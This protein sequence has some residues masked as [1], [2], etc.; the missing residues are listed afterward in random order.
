M[1]R[2][3]VTLTVNGTEQAEFIESGTMLADFLRYKL[4]LM[5]TK[6]GVL[7][8]GRIVE[9]APAAELFRAP[10]HPYTRML[11]DAVPDLAMTGRQRT[12]ER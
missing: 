4:G 5:A 3:P 7:Y 9:V 10:K 2:V 8:L 6:V 1:A 12:A 11:L